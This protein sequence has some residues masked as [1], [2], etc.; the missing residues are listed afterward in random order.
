VNK[1]IVVAIGLAVLMGG[2][3]YAQTSE[4]AVHEGVNGWEWIPA[5]DPMTDVPFVNFA[6]EPNEQGFLNNIMLVV[7]Y[8]QNVWLWGISRALGWKSD[9]QVT[10]RLGKEAAKNETFRSDGGTYLLHEGW[11]DIKGFLNYPQVLIRVE[12]DDP[13]LFDVSQPA[14]TLQ[15]DMTGLAE[16][17][18]MAG[19]NVEAA[20]AE[21]PTTEFRELV[22]IG[23][24]QDVQA[25]I[26]QGANVNERYGNMGWTPL[27]FAASF[28]TEPGVITT[29]LTAGAD[30]EARDAE[31]KTALMWAVLYNSSYP[32]VITT[33]LKAGADGK[34]RDNTGN[35][36]FDYAKINDKLKGTDALKQLEEASK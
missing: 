33:L 18:Q 16:T 15:F 14:T 35:T 8:S 30:I 3:A 12:N 25:A 13:T 29:L 24:S 27:R 10:Y 17:I 1:R 22:K 4:N 7:E 32:E 23:T 31:G 21:T 20:S 5:T 11:T 9:K 6:K 26:D 28:N 36:A 19:L 2:S 34:A